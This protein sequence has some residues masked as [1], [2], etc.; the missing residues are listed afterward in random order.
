MGNPL[1]HHLKSTIL[2]SGKSAYVQEQSVLH[3]GFCY[4]SRNTRFQKKIFLI[5]L[6]S[7]VTRLRL[8]NQKRSPP[9]QWTSFFLHRSDRSTIYAQQCSADV[10]GMRTKEIKHSGSNFLR[11]SKSVP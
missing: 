8:L 4:D 1:P 5:R 7:S 10:I 6:A 2:L 3:P 11:S 9:L